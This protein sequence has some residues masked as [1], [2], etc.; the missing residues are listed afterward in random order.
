MSVREYIGSVDAN[1][2]AGTRVRASQVDGDIKFARCCVTLA[3]VYV[4]QH[5]RRHSSVHNHSSHLHAT[6]RAQ[7]AQ[8]Y[9]CMCVCVRTS[10]IYGTNARCVVSA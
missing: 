7:S 8:S 1:T 9:V 3:D 4:K 10:A 6:Y 2:R 5:E